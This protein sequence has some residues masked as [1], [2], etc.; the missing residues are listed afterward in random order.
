MDFGWC[1]C[2]INLFYQRVECML[3]KGIRVA[4]CGRLI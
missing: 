2:K 1:F 4:V 3:E